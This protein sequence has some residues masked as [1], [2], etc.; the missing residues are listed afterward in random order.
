MFNKFKSQSVIN[1]LL[2]IGLIFLAISVISL[3][4]CSSSPKAEITTLPA[5]PSVT[6]APAASATETADTSESFDGTWT[7]DDGSFLA[8]IS[9]GVIVINLVTDDSESLYWKGTFPTVAEN[10][11]AFVSDGDVE[12]MY[13]SLFGSQDETKEFM[14]EDGVIKFDMSM[15][16]TTTHVRLAQER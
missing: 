1:V 2:S 3:S 14:Y 15:A 10:N 4:G 8:D 11:T 16:G 9:A 6:E 13:A 5:V 7:N 12:A